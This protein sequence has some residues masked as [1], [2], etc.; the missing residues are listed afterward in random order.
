MTTD[1]E[2]IVQIEKEMNWKKGGK[3]MDRAEKNGKRRLERMKINQNHFS[4]KK[5]LL[6]LAY[7]LV[8]RQNN[9]PLIRLDCSLR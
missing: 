5:K 4:E 1:E 2:I 3:K 7:T 9:I 6:S 8:S